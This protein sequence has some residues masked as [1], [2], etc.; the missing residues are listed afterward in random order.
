MLVVATVS[1]CRDHMGNSVLGAV[2]LRVG[3]EIDLDATL[4]FD[5]DMAVGRHSRLGSWCCKLL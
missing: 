2:F 5:S 3:H 4:P 1:G